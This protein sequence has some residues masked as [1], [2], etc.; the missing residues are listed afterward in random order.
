MTG[1]PYHYVGV[2][3]L[4]GLTPL[5]PKMILLR[6]RVLR[7]LHWNSLGNWHETNF[8]PLVVIVR[9]LMVAMAMTLVVLDL[10]GKL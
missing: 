6:I 7:F 4:L 8:H 10:T 1:F 5:V 2:V 9:A 3:A